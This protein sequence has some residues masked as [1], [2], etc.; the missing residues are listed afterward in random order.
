MYTVK[1]GASEQ[2]EKEM[3]AI[4]L[5]HFLHQPWIQATLG[6]TVTHL[7]G[8]DETPI[9]KWSHPSNKLSFICCQLS[10][11]QV[12]KNYEDAMHMTIVR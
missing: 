8:K 3:S 7:E 12:N 5:N 6:L 1:Y 10:N 2:S 4:S 11:V 9:S